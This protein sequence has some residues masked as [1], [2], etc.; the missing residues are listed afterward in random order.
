MTTNEYVADLSFGLTEQRMREGLEEELLRYMHA[1]GG[2]PTIR[3]IAAAIARI[4]EEDHLKMAEQL[5][6][7]GVRMSLPAKAV[8]SD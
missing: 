8:D 2:A 3:A 7:A 6:R 4:M 5:T 1:E